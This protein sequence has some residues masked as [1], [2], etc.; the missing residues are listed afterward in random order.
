MDCSLSFLVD[1]GAT[2]VRERV[3]LKIVVVL[4]VFLRLCFLQN[5]PVFRRGQ[6]NGV[7]SLEKS[8]RYLPL[9]KR[10]LERFWPGSAIVV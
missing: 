6:W 10:C 8:V 1:Q 3:A 5:L 9:L 2:Q 7:F 4:M